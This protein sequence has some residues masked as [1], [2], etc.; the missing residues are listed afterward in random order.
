VFAFVII[1]PFILLTKLGILPKFVS[2]IIVIIIMVSVLCY[3]MYRLALSPDSI[4]NRDNYNYDHINIPDDIKYK[5]LLKNSDVQ[6]KNDTLLYDK[7]GLGFCIGEECCTDNMMYDSA[8]DKCVTNRAVVSAVEG[9]DN[10]NNNLNFNSIFNNILKPNVLNIIE[11][12]NSL[13]KF[14]NEPAQI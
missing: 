7:L 11:P 2:L 14:N 12:L 8:I 1:I 5:K 13:D 6:S 10:L 4:L 9:F 3:I